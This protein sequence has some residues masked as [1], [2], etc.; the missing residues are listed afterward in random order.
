MAALM[1]DKVILVIIDGLKYQT[2]IEQCGFLE[3]L[4]ESKKARRMKM[5]AV[6]PTLS[7]PIY[8]TLH[9]GLEPLEHGITSNDNLRKS[10]FKNIFAIA[11]ASGLVTAAAAHSFFST[12]YNEDPY[13]PI[14]D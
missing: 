5:I 12:L 1:K 13:I 9:T 4:V 2:A 8:E 14:R 10:K 6:L 7:A 3:A 11:K